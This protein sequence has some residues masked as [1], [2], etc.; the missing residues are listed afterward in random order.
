MK[1]GGSNGD[2]IVMGSPLEYAK[3][4]KIHHNTHCDRCILRIPMGSHHNIDT[5]GEGGEMSLKIVNGLGYSVH[6]DY[7]TI[8]SKISLAV[9]FF[10]FFT[11][12]CE[13]HIFYRPT[14]ELNVSKP[15]FQ[16]K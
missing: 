4:I 12:K 1:K 14:P 7:V 2:S 13:M 3:Y 5:I 8:S 16:K 15:R 6:C 11:Q 9:Y 10:I